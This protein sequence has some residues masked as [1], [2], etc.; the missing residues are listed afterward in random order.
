MATGL[1]LEPIVPSSSQ[2]EALLDALWINELRK[3]TWLNL[4]V[5]DKCVILRWNLF[6]L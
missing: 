6:Y 5:W 2:P 3:R 1:H 4:V